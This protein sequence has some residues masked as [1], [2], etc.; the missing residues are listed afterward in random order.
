MATINRKLQL[1][2]VQGN[3]VF[4]RASLDNIQRSKN[5]G[6]D[7]II[8]TLDDSG[9]IDTAILP[10]AASS[11][12]M[13][14]AI[15]IA[16]P[17]GAVVG[18]KYYNITQNKVYTYSGSSWGNAVTPSVDKLYLTK[19]DNNI[20]RYDGTST[21]IDVSTHFTVLQSVAND[22]V[23]ASSTGVPS[24]HAVSVALQKKQDKMSGV[25]PISVDGTGAISLRYSS[26]LAVEGN[27]LTVPQSYITGTVDDLMMRDADP[28][29]PETAIVDGGTVY[30]ILGNY[31]VT[32]T[33]ST[34]VV[35]DTRVPTEK[36]VRD[37]INAYV[38][39]GGSSVTAGKAINVDGGSIN[40]TTASTQDVLEGLE[41]LAG[42]TVATPIMDRVN[43]PGNLRG[44]LSIG[45]AV[46]VSCAPLEAWKFNGI[47]RGNEWESLSNTWLASNKTGT[48][49]LSSFSIRWVS[50]EINAGANFGF[51]LNAQSRSF[52]KFAQ[53]L[54]YLY[55]AD[56]FNSGNPVDYITFKTSSGFNPIAAGTVPFRYDDLPD[57]TSIQEADKVY[58]RIAGITEDAALLLQGRLKSGTTMQ[59][60]IKNWRQYEVTALTDEAIA[61]IAQ[62]PDP[63]LFFRDVNAHNIKNKY[64]VK[65]DMVCPF[66][67]T[68]SMPDNSDL[69]VGAGLAYKLKY[70]DS[71]VHKITVDT[72]PENGYGWDAHLQLFV[73]DTANVAF[74]PPLN[75][76]DPLTPNAGQNL[77]V[78]F[79]NG[80]ANVYVDDIDVGYV[81]SVASGSTYGSL[82]YGLMN[83]VGEYIVFSNALDGVNV[84]YNISTAGV[85]ARQLTVIGNGPDKTNVVQSG[86]FPYYT[87]CIFQNLSLTTTETSN[88]GAG[89][90]TDL[91]YYSFGFVN[92]KIYDITVVGSHHAIGFGGRSCHVNG[93]WFENVTGSSASGIAYFPYGGEV[94]G[95]TFTNINGFMCVEGYYSPGENSS[96]RALVVS[97]CIFDRQHAGRSIYPRNT[98]LSISDCSFSQY[99]NIN[100]GGSTTTFSGTNILNSTVSGTGTVIF[101]DGAT[102]SSTFGTGVIGATIGNPLATGSILL[103]NITISGSTS[104][105][106]LFRPVNTSL[107]LRNCTITNCLCNSDSGAN[108]PYAIHASSGSTLHITDVIIRGNTGSSSNNIYVQYGNAY[109]VGG[110]TCGAVYTY[111]GT[112][113]L[114]GTNTCRIGFVSST[115][116]SGRFVINPNSVLIASSGV[117]PTT[118]DCMMYVGTYDEAT[119]TIVTTGT[120]TVV[121]NGITVNITGSGTTIDVNGLHS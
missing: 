90:I 35:E 54:R 2:D 76:L 13:L 77:T 114:S 84:E 30:S 65:Q 31:E 121:L 45:Q 119:G 19:N 41:T 29:S 70:T 74:V 93:C 75:L 25:A 18:D 87:K 64:L 117:N 22:P 51:S 8:V 82:S 99:D 113:I 26:G 91:L 89:N 46:D 48:W 5:D 62:L 105:G 28:A 27:S 83:D 57:G 71:N 56:V 50:A 86:L 32:N 107:T 101:A 96:A 60:D 69:T 88:N 40:V 17:V 47:N 24:E 67:P 118:D 106:A 14:L 108:Q 23:D 42:A 72:I 80:Q 16:A 116:T 15:A 38:A 78:K 79:R 9:H 43:T 59:I 92:C 7:A 98:P 10:S 53:G 73:K 63:D 1:R 21:M 97:N 33:I 94:T 66:I 39:T 12:D 81:V 104:K 112:V 20:Y 100:I 85:V 109:V 4:P 52:P 68:I 110:C 120:A 58:A 3:L 102:V 95:S 61:Y 111:R 37:A 55:I 115:A 11:V 44:A 36:A 49:F 6:R 103:E 34:T